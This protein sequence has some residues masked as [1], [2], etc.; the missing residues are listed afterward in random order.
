M[1]HAR[2]VEL[3]QLVSD[4]VDRHPEAVDQAITNARARWEDPGLEDVFV[5]LHPLLKAFASE[6]GIELT[7]HDPVP[8]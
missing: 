2:L 3:E 5:I 1:T 4:F 7:D 8:Y 6:R